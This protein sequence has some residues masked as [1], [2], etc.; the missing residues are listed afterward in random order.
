M[1]SRG[2][3]KHSEPLPMRTWVEIDHSSLRHNLKAV[4]KLAGRAGI[5]A[6]VANKAIIKRDL[7]M[8][9]PQFL[10]PVLPG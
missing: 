4:R 1:M 7:N 3:K 2:R 6:V 9:R 5:M 8:L 10:K